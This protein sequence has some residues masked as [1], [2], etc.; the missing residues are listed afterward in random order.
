MDDK[1]TVKVDEYCRSVSVPSVWAVG[2]V[3]NRKPLTPVARAEA[4]FFAQHL[5]GCVKDL[6]LVMTE[7]PE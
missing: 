2:D 3:I 7:V 1:G 5:F 4:S 6:L